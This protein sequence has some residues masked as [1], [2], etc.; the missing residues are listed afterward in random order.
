MGEAIVLI[1]TVL[2]IFTIVDIAVA[3][4]KAWRETND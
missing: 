3:F 1:A 2:S 4:R